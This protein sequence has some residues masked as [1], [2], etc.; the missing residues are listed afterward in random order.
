MVDEVLPHAPE[1]IW[2]ALTKR[3]GRP[4]AENAGYC[5]SGLCK[6]KRFTLKTSPAGAWDGVI[7]CEVLEAIPNQRFVF[8]WKS[9]H[10]EECRLRRAARHG[11]NLCAFEN[12]RR[13]APSPRPFRVRLPR[14]ETAFRNMGEGWKKVVPNIGAI[15]G[16]QVFSKK[17]H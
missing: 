3:T 12:R 7:Q 17:P 4:L 5:I 14:N 16:E 8:S 15:A 1:T 9:G 13:H 10:A 11:R 2:K 6:G